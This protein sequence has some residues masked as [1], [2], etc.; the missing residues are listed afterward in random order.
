MEKDQD[1]AGKV[2]LEGEHQS[3]AKYRP[4]GYHMIRSIEINNYRCFEKVKLE[5]CRRVNVIVGGN[6]SGKTALLEA[7]FMSSSAN[8]DLALRMRAFRGY[9]RPP[10]GATQNQI[11]DAVWGE[12]FH[13]FNK[14]RSI[15]I[16]VEGSREHNRSLT[17]IYR[18]RE[19]WVSVVQP[20]RKKSE[21]NRPA[22]I[23]FIWRGPDKVLRTI[24]VNMTPEGK[25]MVPFVSDVP[26][27][28]AFF[29]SNATYSSHETAWR[30]SELNKAGRAREIERYLEEEFHVRDLSLEMS[31]GVPL[32]FGKIESVPEKVP[33]NVVSGALNR[34][35]PIMCSIVNYPKG[36]ILIDEIEDGLYYKKMES[37]WEMLLKLADEN[38]SQIFASTHSQECLVA[39]AK[40]AEKYPEKFAL[41]KATNTGKN[42]TLE[43]F[44]GDDF[45]ATVEAGFDPRT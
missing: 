28:L 14:Q 25:F 21:K 15:M 9:E 26:V 4:S 2:F 12:L 30:F 44:D 5:G 10:Q 19:K 6:G 45:A 31:A 11:E 1:Y 35:V 34:L 7:L 8:P 3:D 17:I 24:P 37:I 39:A 36:A 33:L 41:I 20:G 42:S 22:P 13:A 40:I 32:I 27:E 43:L 23:T 38:D 16:S 18:V 29:G